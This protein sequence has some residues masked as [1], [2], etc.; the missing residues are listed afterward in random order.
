MKL[1]TKLLIVVVSGGCIWGLSYLSSI[2][3]DMAS[4]LASINVAIM[5]ICSYFTGYPPK[6]N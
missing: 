6:D 5:A 2:K 4:M 3:P 1:W